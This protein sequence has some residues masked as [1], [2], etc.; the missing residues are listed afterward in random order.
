MTRLAA[1]LLALL[2]MS[3]S[4]FAQ[5]LPLPPPPGGLPGPPGVVRPA[6]PQAPRDAAAPR[7]GTA[8]IRGRVVAADTG[9]PLRKAQVRATSAEL[10]E[11]RL[12]TTDD[13]GVFEIKELPAGRFQLTA[14]KG[15]FVQLQY[16]QTRPF[17]AGKPLEV[18]DGQTI[19]KVEFSLP[20]GAI[21]TGR[22]VDEI[23]EPADGVQVSAMRY[24][25]VQGRRQLVSSG[26]SGITN[27]I[28]EYRIFGVPPG[29]YYVSATLRTLNPFDVSSGD[30]SGYAPTFHP[31]TTNV[32]EAQR[33]TI[34]L[35]Q[36]RNG[37]DVVLS[38][39][40]L[41][42]ITGTAVDSEGRPATGALTVAMSQGQ[43]GI[44]AYS[45][46]QFRP[47]GSFTISNIAPG[48]YTIS[49][50]SLGANLGG[51]PAPDVISASVTVAGEDIQDLRLMGVKRSTVTGRVLLP[52]ATP[53]AI[54]A[55][56]IQL[57]A[58]P[59]QPSPIVTLTG[60][61]AT[62]R[63]NDD[64][65]FEMRVAP[66]QQVIRL[67]GQPQGPTLKAVRI[68]GT[69]V[70]DTGI[71][72]RASEDVSGV[73]VELTTQ[74]SELSGTVADARG[75]TVKDYSIVVF[76]RDS[77]RWTL[78]S[79]Y[80]G[81]GRPDQDGRFKVRNLPPGDYYAIALDY[82]EPGAGTDPEFL[83]KIRDRATPFSMTEGGIQ[84][85]DLK[86]VSGL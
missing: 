67:G 6:A 13:K 52:Q 34:E 18:A 65:T 4:A 60:S 86:L 72:F 22:V 66:G 26:R 35:G 7:T 20:R 36:T 39:V 31:G 53:G 80:F 61:G 48:S 63:V 73:E 47:D 58:T 56:T 70:T 8:R 51:G 3:S 17:E 32:A 62:S 76:A 40:R 68:N 43:G 1:H 75:R 85:L 19:D 38:P 74:V 29:Q 16:G 23:G 14:T 30:S 28:G 24:G 79:R 46:G 42:R 50:G 55:S 33:L 54:R 49:A 41:A 15:S 11:N 37:V 5:G 83:E 82:V 27:D 64:F 78:G 84:P 71:D 77:A 57:T 44:S 69:D 9:E 45:G 59:M 25:Y 2:L 81:N 21:V 12:A 10:R